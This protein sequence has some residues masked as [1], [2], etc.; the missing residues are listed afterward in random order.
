M[1][2]N[3]VEERSVALREMRVLDLISEAV[4]NTTFRRKLLLAADMLKQHSLDVEI[5]YHPD[6]GTGYGMFTE[7]MKT[8]LQMEPGVVPGSVCNPQEAGACN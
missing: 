2:T 3:L 4:D 7:L 8:E 1:S 5:G 6:D